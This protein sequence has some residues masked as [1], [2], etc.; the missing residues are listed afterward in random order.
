MARA[1]LCVCL[2]ALLLLPVPNPTA[3]ADYAF[4]GGAPDYADEWRT[5]APH[6]A[7]RRGGTNGSAAAAAPLP[8]PK[9]PLG[10][11]PNFVFILT[12]D[13]DRILGRDAYTAL[14]SL[15]IM[16]TLKKRLLGEGA[17]VENFMVNT[18]ICC[19]SRTEFFT[20]RYFHNVGPPNDEKGTCMHAD[21]TLAGDNRTG[22]F[23]LMAGA[24]YNVGVFGKVTN[25]QQRILTQMSV[26]NSA[27]TIDSP[28]NYN[29][30]MGMTYY[31]FSAANGSHYT[32]TLSGTAPIF[33]TA[34]QT[35]QIGNRTLRWLDGAID[36]SLGLTTRGG[37]GGDA[38]DADGGSAAAD[39][40]KPQPFF[41][42]IGPHAPHY[43]AQPAPWYEH[44]FD[45]VTAPRTPNYNLS[46]PD[47]AQHV[48][49]NPPL[50]AAVEC[51]ENQHFRDR[52]A[53][54]LSVDDIIGAVYDRLEARGVL[55]ST[56]I[57]YSSDHGY[58]Q[59]QWRI[60]TSKQHPY[61]TDIRVPF[62]MR[63][64]GVRAGGNFTTQI[65]G[66]VDVL[67]TMLHLAAGAAYVQAADPD[68]R[69]MAHFMVDGVLDDDDHRED[70]GR[71]G[72]NGGNGGNGGKWRDHFLNEYYSVGTYQNDH[73]QIWQDGSATSDAC[74][75]GRKS[76]SGPRYP[77][78]G[79]AGY[80]PG[81]ACVESTGV[82]DGNCYFVDSTHSNSWRQLRVMNATMN[83]NYVE[84]DPAWK[85]QST[86]P[87]G[88][89]L[90]HYEL[91]DVATDPHQMHNIYGKASVATKTALHAQLTAYFG[92]RGA[93]CP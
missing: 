60:G 2:L 6:P 27:T 3:A 70:D 35:T 76:G 87:T 63:G 56:Y 44:A 53:S 43:P 47:K 73:S 24:G 78:A 52:W 69:S 33:G 61:E 20:G 62:L 50:N 71:S 77:R 55:D 18:P 80:P 38:A 9:P 16:P 66:N 7:P 64:P 4:A 46:S 19:P 22:L 86:D 54:L 30:F 8:A 90:Q 10:Y 11:Q 89:G 92:C 1:T 15:E 48:R 83:W 91:Y 36:R 21:T 41:A 5:A 74:G 26:A 49:Q 45:D 17:V 32:E 84:Y 75:T 67:P 85:F 68:G 42:Y 13:Q 29:D 57:L 34:Y 65:S 82:G 72:G 14:G 12:D 39:A 79:A 31:H 51:W 23:G 88:A 58:K 40:H 37:P 81:A 59:G 93:S 25:D 28:V